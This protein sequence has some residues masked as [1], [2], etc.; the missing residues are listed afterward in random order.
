MMKETA[1]ELAK[2]TILS[3]GM[4]IAIFCLVGITADIKHGG[5]FCLNNYRFTKMVAASILIGLGYGLPSIVYR[6]ESLPMPIKVIIHMGIGCTVYTLIAFA[7][8]WL[9]SATSIGHGIAIAAIQLAV[10]FVIWALFM[11]SYRKEA[12]QMNDKIQAMK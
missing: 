12:K 5:S 8:G 6:K 11:R 1:K 7:V 3:I 10:A 4:A 9:G 2:N